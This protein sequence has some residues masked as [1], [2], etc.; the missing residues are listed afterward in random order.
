VVTLEAS[1]LAWAEDRVLSYAGAITSD[2]NELLRW[3][4]D[5]LSPA[6]GVRSRLLSKAE[7]LTLSN[8]SKGL[9]FSVNGTC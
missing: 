9:V 5:S 4:M 7:P 2:G 3:M 6:V 8:P 1:V